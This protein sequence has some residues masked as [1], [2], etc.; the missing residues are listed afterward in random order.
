MPDETLCVV[1]MSGGAR[2]TRLG[3]NHSENPR[4]LK[5]AAR[6]G[7]T[8]RALIHPRKL[9]IRVIE[10]QYFGGLLASAGETFHAPL[11]KPDSV[12]KTATA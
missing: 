9:R 2:P 1:L 6:Y 3:S 5:F 7:W 12:T 8:K 4:E 10:P 11:A